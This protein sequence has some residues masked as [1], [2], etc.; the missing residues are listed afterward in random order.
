[1]NYWGPTGNN[2][3]IKVEIEKYKGEPPTRT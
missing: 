3:D 2:R 1:L